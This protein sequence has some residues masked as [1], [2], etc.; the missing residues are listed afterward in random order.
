MNAPCPSGLPVRRSRATPPAWAEPGCSAEPVCRSQRFS[1]TWIAAHPFTHSSSGSR[2]CRSSR[3]MPFSS[4]QPGVRARS[5]SAFVVRPGY[6]RA[7][8]PFAGRARGRDG[9]RTRVEHL[10]ERR[11]DRCCR[12]RRLRCV[13]DHRQESAISAE[14]RRE[15]A[16]H[17]GALDNALAAYPSRS[18]PNRGAGPRRSLQPCR[19]SNRSK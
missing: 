6:A 15:A 14:P 17:R 2:A 4:T 18:S 12:E 9:A 8:A 5:F 1:R 10:A 19:D 3:C 7:P 13:L 11:A 16:C